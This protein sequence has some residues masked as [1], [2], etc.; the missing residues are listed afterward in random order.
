MCRAH[1]STSCGLSPLD[2]VHIHDLVERKG[3][4]YI[5]S[6]DCDEA[7]DIV[8][9]RVPWMPFLSKGLSTLCWLKCTGL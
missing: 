3:D 2:M 1:G 9:T 4:D 5:K 7:F 6:S 8:V